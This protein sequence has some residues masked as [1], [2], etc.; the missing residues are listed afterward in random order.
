M[1]MDLSK[2]SGPYSW[3]LVTN[4]V[5]HSSTLLVECWLSTR[6]A[7]LDRQFMKFKI[8]ICFCEFPGAIRSKN[9]HKKACNRIEFWSGCFEWLNIGVKHVTKSQNHNIE[10]ICVSRKEKLSKCYFSECDYIY[11]A[12]GF[13]LFPSDPN[14]SRTGFPG[15][16]TT[17]LKTKRAR[18]PNL[19]EGRSCEVN[20]ARSVL[21][22]RRFPERDTD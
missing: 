19:Q 20:T 6:F 8:Y 11:G 14:K 16:L 1:S 12:L 7:K 22:R 4:V 3:I 18:G 5:E 21:H 17:S 2:L 13:S 9:K 10:D 15:S